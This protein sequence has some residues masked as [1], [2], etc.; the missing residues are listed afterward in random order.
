M[1]ADQH[2]LL[3][4]HDVPDAA[5]PAKRAPHV[6]WRS[7]DGKWRSTSGRGSTAL[8]LRDHLEPFAKLAER[9]EE[10]VE[11]AKTAEDYFS[12]LFEV[13]PLLRT[14]RNALRVLQEAREAVPA[15]KELI[16]IRDAAQELERALEL[17]QGYAKDGLE[18]T[19]ARNA[20]ESA[21]NGERMN[22]SSHRLNL[23]IALFLPITAVGSILG[24][25]MRHGFEEWH[26][27]FA[28]W[29][30]AGAALLI[31]YAIRAGLPKD[32]VRQQPE[33]APATKRR[34]P[35]RAPADRGRA[36]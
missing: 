8:V 36:T 31:G 22:R 5:T 30:V 14:S 26:A 18:F 2:L 32:D 29:A 15:D 9:L 35:S 7:P 23:L 1:V 13:A 20:E 34:R 6:F 33:A 21:R 3:I 24:I 12:V 10:R 16:S 17:L 4:L 19:S 28:F 11:Q 27:P 25:N